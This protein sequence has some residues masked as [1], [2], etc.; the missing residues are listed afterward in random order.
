[1]AEL[2]VTVVT[3]ARAAQTREWVVLLPPGATVFDALKACGL[4]AAD[5]AYAASVW[6]KSAAVQ[7]HLHDQ[8][9]VEW[10]RALKVDPKVARRERFA[11]QGSRGAGLFSKRRPG[12]KS[13]Y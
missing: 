3:S 7:H 8:D 1:M 6:G 5:P 2:E 12:A 10:C 9:R 4:N 11:S 13:G